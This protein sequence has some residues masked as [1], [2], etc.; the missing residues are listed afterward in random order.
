MDNEKTKRVF[1]LG[2]MFGRNQA[3]GSI[4]KVCSAANAQTLKDIRDQKLYLD[5]DMNWE[6]FCKR[7]LGITRPVADKIIHL[8]EEFGPGYFALA[9]LI[10]IT[11]DHY[12]LIAPSISGNALQYGGDVITIEPENAPAL[13]AA[14]DD[15]RRAAEES[16]PPPEPDTFEQSLKK[17]ERALRDATLRL[18]RLSAMNLE[19]GDRARLQ[20]LVGSGVAKLNRIEPV[21]I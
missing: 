17:A 19:A 21:H 18:Q 1:E 2:T 8:L 15:L 6:E 12:R 7:H 5:L 9:Q 20:S 4:A 14:A 10:R 16:G 13:A 3:F 11:P